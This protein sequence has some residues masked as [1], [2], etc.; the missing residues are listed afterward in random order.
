MAQIQ[1]HD[2]RLP[3]SEHDGRS[4][5]RVCVCM[6]T[7]ANFPIVGYITW[8]TQVCLQVKIGVATTHAQGQVS[9]CGHS[10]NT[11]MVGGGVQNGRMNTCWRGSPLPTS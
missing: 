11:R 4:G 1:L 9:V 10:T 2:V 6:A 8:H 7:L 5:G 3:A